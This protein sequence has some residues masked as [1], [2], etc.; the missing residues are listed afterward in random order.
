[1][2]KNN[3]SQIEI[4]LKKFTEI[5][6]EIKTLNKLIGAANLSK[7]SIVNLIKIKPGYENAVY[8]SL[9]FELDA[10]LSNK[11]P[12]K[13]V[14]KNIDNLDNIHNSIL[15][16][17]KAPNELNLILSQ[18]SLVES[19]KSDALE[20]Q[21]K[22]EVGQMLVDKNGKIWRWD[23]FISEQNL[24]NKKI[25]DSQLKINELEKETKIL[26]KNYFLK[27]AI[28][29]LLK[30]INDSLEKSIAKENNDLEYNYKKLD[31]IMAN[32]ST[33]KEKIT[34]TNYNNQKDNEEKLKELIKSRESILLRLT[35]IKEKEKQL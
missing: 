28:T 5:N 33:Q 17:V 31:E 16:F 9:M 19:R 7:E 10:T 22:L 15:N 1:M 34:F 18:I 8:A 23:G 2:L 26:E 32:I 6:T 13:W 20:K 14:K 21:K 35:E 3:E 24:Q 29:H 11:S 30:N 25:I 27:E 4:D 12:K